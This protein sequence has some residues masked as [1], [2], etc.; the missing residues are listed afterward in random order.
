MTG[1]E[2]R[3]SSCRCKS[4]GAVCFA[5]SEEARKALACEYRALG[6][7][8]SSVTASG[9]VVDGFPSAFRQRLVAML[10]ALLPA[11]RRKS[12]ACHRRRIVA[13]REK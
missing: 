10:P 1:T 6:T 12:R 2:R 5:S 7:C 4:S 11:A 9:C 8:S 13:A 3:A